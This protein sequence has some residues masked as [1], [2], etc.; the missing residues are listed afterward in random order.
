[1]ARSAPR[2][3]GELQNDSAG[4]IEAD[5]GDLGV[6]VAQREVG[7]PL[8]RGHAR[9]AMIFCTVRIGTPDIT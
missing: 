7:V 6:K 8:G 4:Q 1:M 5:P 9:V 3:P 2:N